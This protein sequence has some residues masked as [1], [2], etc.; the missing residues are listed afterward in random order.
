MTELIMFNIYGWIEHSISLHVNREGITCTNVQ[1]Q[2]IPTPPT[3]IKH[4]YR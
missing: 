4:N 2:I 1:Q 3:I